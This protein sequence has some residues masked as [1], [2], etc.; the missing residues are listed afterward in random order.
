VFA[1]RDVPSSPPGAGGPGGAAPGTRPLTQAPAGST[2]QGLAGSQGNG[3]DWRAV[4][5]LNG[6]E[7][8]RRLEPGQLI[9][10]NPPRVGVGPSVGLGT[11]P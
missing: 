10:L 8:P 7:N 4:A 1:F 11:V 3:A 5:D 9:D 6:I 2:L